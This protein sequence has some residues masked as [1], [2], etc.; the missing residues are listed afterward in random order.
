MTRGM[1]I[2]S[3]SQQLEKDAVAVIERVQ[4]TQ[5]TRF[6]V[7]RRR[8]VREPQPPGRFAQHLGL[9]LVA[10]R[11]DFSEHPQVLGVGE[12]RRPDTVGEVT[13]PNATIRTVGSDARLGSSRARGSR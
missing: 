1:P 10:E 4:T 7:S 6:L 9:R 2:R 3:G 13:P 5:L 12:L 11:Q 8:Q